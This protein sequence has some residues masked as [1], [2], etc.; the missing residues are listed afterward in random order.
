MHS[1]SLNDSA[2]KNAVLYQTITKSI[3]MLCSIFAH[4]IAKDMI[5]TS[6]ELGMSAF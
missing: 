5:A 1:N 2:A 4:A 6:T 3:N